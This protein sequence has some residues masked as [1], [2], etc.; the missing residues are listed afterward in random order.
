MSRSRGSSSPWLFRVSLLTLLA[1][2]PL[3][4]MGGLVTSKG[5]GLAVP[6]W[7]NSFGYNMWLFP[8]SKWIGGIFY[9]HT[10]RLLATLVGFL[11]IAMVLVAWGVGARPSIRK[12]L[13]SGGAV[14]LLGGIAFYAAVANRASDPKDPLP[15]LAVGLISLGA[16][17]L[18]ASLCRHREERRWMRWLAV[19]IFGCVCIQGVVGGARVDLISLELAI[20]HGVFAQLVVCLLAFACLANTGWWVRAQQF[21]QTGMGFGTSAVKIAATAAFFIVLAQ[22]IVGATMRHYGA[23]LAIPDLPLAYGHLL[24]PTNPTDLAAANAYRTSLGDTSLKPV[25]LPQI[26]LAFA[27]R[28]GAVLVTLALLTLFAIIY[29]RA[30]CHRLLMS[31]AYI[32]LVLLASQVTLGLLTVYF[33]KPA[34]ITTLHHTTGALILITTSTLA[35]A[36]YRMFPSPVRESSQ[37]RV[38]VA[39]AVPVGA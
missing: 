24:P 7:P 9:E 15:H 12:A 25:T 10:H 14:A 8:P 21:Q 37:P 39:P 33:R 13:L 4:F 31:L 16:V 38:S 22:L 11:S 2:L 1:S 36:A 19:V 35:A 23:G 18:I 3:V 20:V 17:A 26:W 6:D 28:S 27:H 32:L 34:D 5:A 30:R 29:R